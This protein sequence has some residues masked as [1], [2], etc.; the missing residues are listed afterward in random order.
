MELTD[1]EHVRK[2]ELPITKADL[3]GV[4]VLMAE[5]NDL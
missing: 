1:E 2:Q 3:T 4:K 5:D